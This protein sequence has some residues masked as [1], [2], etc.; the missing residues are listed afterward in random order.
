M[1]G[2]FVVPSL[3]LIVIRLGGDHRMNEHREFYRELMTRVVA[4]IETEPD[5]IIA[6]AGDD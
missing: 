6:S 2:C 4:S 3:D 5:R 1:R